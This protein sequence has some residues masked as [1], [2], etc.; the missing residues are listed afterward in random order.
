MFARVFLKTFWISVSPWLRTIAAIIVGLLTVAAARADVG[1]S[2]PVP[3][4]RSQQARYP[5]SAPISF[6]D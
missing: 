2:S 1:A 6:V 3:E 4:A 5:H